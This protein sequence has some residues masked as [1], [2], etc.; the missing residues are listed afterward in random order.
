MRR[1]LGTAAAM[2]FEE[3]DDDPFGFAASD[4]S[5]AAIRGVPD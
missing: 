3:N 2:G 5:G 4:Q 1:F